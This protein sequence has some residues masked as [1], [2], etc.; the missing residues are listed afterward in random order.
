MQWFSILAGYKLKLLGLVWIALA[1]ADG[2]FQFNILSLVDETNWIDNV[3][4]GFAVFAGRD[5]VDTLIGK[6]MAEL[7]SR[8]K[9]PPTPQDAKFLKTPKD[10]K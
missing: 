4:F 9:L 5:A 3:I 7:S 10:T 2:V 6:V 1:V 8:G